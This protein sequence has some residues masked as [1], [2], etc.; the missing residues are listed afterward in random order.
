AL[1]C[2]R[3]MN[4][5]IRVP[6][7][8]GPR[9]AVRAAACALACAMLLHAAGCARRQPPSGGPPDLEA[10][11]VLAVFPDSGATGVDP[12]AHPW[13][14]LREGMDPR[15]A[16]NAVELA[17]KIEI[18][19]R[20]WSGRKLTLVLDTLLKA[21]HTYTMFVGVDAR[22]RHGNALAGG[23]TVPFSTS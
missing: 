14:E 15:T 17:P 7:A 5:R 4:R 19:Q 20:R 1:A 18:K 22:D 2:S 3:P 23:R 10:P 12:A 21:E 13:V 16:G 6:D 11:H 9:R 8:A